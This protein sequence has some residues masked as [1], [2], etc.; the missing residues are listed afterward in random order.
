MLLDDPEEILE[1]V[2]QVKDIYHQFYLC[3]AIDALNQDN[4]SFFSSR[5]SLGNAICLRGT[6][7]VTA[8]VLD[9]D[10]ITKN[11]ENLVAEMFSRRN[12]PLSLLVYFFEIS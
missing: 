11:S 5:M 3:H 7:H 6:C 2:T 4:K 12:A 1:D 9:P 10:W 8:L